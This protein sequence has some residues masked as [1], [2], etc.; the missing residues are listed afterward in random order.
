[1]EPLQELESRV[2]RTLAERLWCRKPLIYSIR[3]RS[4]RSAATATNLLP[5]KVACRYVQWSGRP[6]SDVPRRVPCSLT[7]K[8]RRLGEIHERG[9]TLIELLIVNPDRGHPGRRRRPAVLGYTQDAKLAEGKALAGS[10]WTALQAS[11]N[12]TATPRSPSPTPTAAP[13]WTRGVRRFHRGWTVTPSGATLSSAC[14]Q[15]AYSLSGAI[16]VQGKSNDNS[17][18]LVLL[19]YVSTSTPPTVITCS[20]TA[21]GGNTFNC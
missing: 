17:T 19:N 5:Y 13:V 9:F 14:G 10:V 8:K 18:L 4:S 12:R 7:L 1:M 15:G 20:T 11:R 2:Q 6:I 21:G 3:V 16:G